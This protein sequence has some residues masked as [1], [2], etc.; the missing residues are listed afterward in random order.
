MGNYTCVA[1]N[2]HGNDKIVYEVIVQQTPRPP[3]ILNC[4][5]TYDEIIVNWRTSNND[6]D[7]NDGTIIRGFK[8][9]YRAILSD[10]DLISQQRE[11]QMRQPINN[12]Q[13]INVDYHIHI[14]T[15]KSLLCGTKYQVKVVGYNSIGDSAISS[16]KTVKTKGGVP[17]A[18]PYTGNNENNEPDKIPKTNIEGSYAGFIIANLTSIQIDLLYWQDMGC[19]IKYFIVEYRERL[20]GNNWLLASNN[21]YPTQSR[22]VINNLKANTTY[23]LRVYAFNNAGNSRDEFIIDT[24]DPNKLYIENR[25]YGNQQNKKFSN[26]FSAN[27]DDSYMGNS[28]VHSDNMIYSTS[29]DSSFVTMFDMFNGNNITLSI[30]II[31]IS[32]IG[33]MASVYLCFKSRKL[34]DYNFLLIQLRNRNCSL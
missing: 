1:H 21:I 7:M 25:K 33:G 19:S 29:S 22:Y 5:S 13:E 14:Y 26:K 34:S 32:V 2:L 30:S 4:M 17:K 23:Q 28:V 27:S 3:E 24:L 31:F 12:W 15:L 8:L 10:V 16:Q 20:N 11:H 18:P 9:Y 6:D